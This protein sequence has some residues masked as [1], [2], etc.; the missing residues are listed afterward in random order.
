MT[1]EYFGEKIKSLRL[2]KKLTQEDLAKKIGLVRATVS[3][4]EMNSKYPSIEVVIKLCEFFDVSADYLLG[5]SETKDF[6]FAA[7]S[8]SQLQAISKIVDDLEQYN[9]L[10]KR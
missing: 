5:L 10:K 9:A 1:M 6:Q 2:D 3:A 4:Y 7:L 8:N